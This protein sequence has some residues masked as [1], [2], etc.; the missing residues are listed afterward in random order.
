[1]KT[2]LFIALI[3]LVSCKTEQPKASQ[4]PLIQQE[5]GNQTI[6]KKSSTVTDIP[7]Q[8]TS[9]H[10]THVIVALCDNVNQGIVKVPEAIGNGQDAR[11]NLY[12]GCAYGVKTYFKNQEEWTIINSQKMVNDTILERVVFRHKNGKN[13]LIADAYDGKYIKKATDN[14]LKSLSGQLLQT[15]VLEKDTFGI[16]GNAQLLAFI[17]HNGL[18]EFDLPIENY[19]NKDNKS[20][21]AIILACIS[22]KYFKPYLNKLKANSL[23]V[24]TGLMSPE[25]YTLEAALDSYIGGNEKPHIRLQ[26]AK[27]YDKYQKCSVNAALGL[28]VNE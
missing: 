11:N 10:L 6:I 19:Q 1:M 5:I 18:M 22:Q 3:I 8:N 17:G 27:A 20:R 12:W 7:Y 21:D 26:A 15:V 2:I 4:S 28:L 9:K 23:V 14:Y 25:A 13:I 16:N 24:S